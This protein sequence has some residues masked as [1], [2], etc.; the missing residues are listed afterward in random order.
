MKTNVHLWEYLAEFF[1]NN[2]SYKTIEKI[3]THIL[4][5]I[6][7][8]ENYA[9]KIYGG[10]KYSKARQATDDN[11]M[12]RMRIACWMRKATNTHTQVVLT[13]IAFTP[14]QWLHESAS[15]VRYT[16]I[17]CIVMFT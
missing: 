16:Y 17:A 6:N 12:R 14:Q 13:F 7:F 9:S 11:V 4:Y 15:M 8:S 3:K 1:L 2:I 10:K 5:S